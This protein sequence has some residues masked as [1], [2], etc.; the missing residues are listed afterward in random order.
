MAL[1]PLQ[2]LAKVAK[3][4]ATRRRPGMTTLVRIIHE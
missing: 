1:Q 4:L 3:H 2:A